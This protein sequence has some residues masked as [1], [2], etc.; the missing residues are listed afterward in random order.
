MW[1][2]YLEWPQIDAFFKK[3]IQPKLY[4]KWDVLVK[5]K[6]VFY[7]SSKKVKTI[8]MSAFINLPRFPFV[9]DSPPGITMCN[10]ED[11]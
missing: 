4:T 1:I 6:S 7:S 9:T 11:L 8:E 2:N 3:Y 10:M 5:V